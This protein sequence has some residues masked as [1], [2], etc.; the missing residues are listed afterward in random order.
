MAYPK[1]HNEEVRKKILREARKAFNLRGYDNVTIE[2]VMASA[3]MTHGAFYFHFNSK[4]DLFRQS[5]ALVLE[6]H[7]V[8]KWM[9]EQQAQSA[10]QQLVNAYLSPRHLESMEES[11]PL[12]TH[13]AEIAR[14][15]DV[16]K[17]IFSSVLRAMVETIQLELEDKTDGEARALIVASLCVGGLSLARGVA[18]P[19]L[20]RKL[21]S[22]AHTYACELANWTMPEIRAQRA[23][24]P[25]IE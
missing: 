13:S 21:L 23:T 1:G 19:E 5:V 12:V 10:A 24:K 9:P 7:P 25:A 8:G 3:G 17:S 4:A 6:E 22:A 15:G 16:A 20:A 14:S 18:D 2:Q 11:C